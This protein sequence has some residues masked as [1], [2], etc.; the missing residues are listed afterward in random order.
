MPLESIHTD[1]VIHLPGKPHDAARI[2]VTTPIDLKQHILNGVLGMECPNF[3]PGQVS[4]VRPQFAA[5]DGHVVL[6]GK[7][8]RVFG[9]G[10]AQNL[11]LFVFKL[12]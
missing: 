3:L 6:G 1:N 12:H 4:K 5:M 7:A 10:H 8:I 11:N 9:V 2:N